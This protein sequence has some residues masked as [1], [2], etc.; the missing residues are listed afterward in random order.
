MQEAWAQC[1]SWSTDG[2]NFQTLDHAVVPRINKD[3][4]D[5]KVIWY[6]PTKKWVMV[7]WVERGDNEQHSMQISYFAGS[8]KLDKCKCGLWGYW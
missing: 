7:M 3:N 6:E 1:L 2:R 8:Y 4:R 5:P